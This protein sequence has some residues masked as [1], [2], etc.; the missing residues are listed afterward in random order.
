MDPNACLRRIDEADMHDYGEI[1]DACRVLSTW[2][3]YGGFEPIWNDYRLGTL[4]FRR[5]RAKQAGR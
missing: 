3:A 1:V 4:R 5:W 2:L